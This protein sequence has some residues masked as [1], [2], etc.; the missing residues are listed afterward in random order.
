MDL[1]PCRVMEMVYVPGSRFLNSYPPCSSVSALRGAPRSGPPESFTEIPA[2]PESA[3]SC[4]V[5][6]VPWMEPA[7]A[8][9]FAG[10]ASCANAEEIANKRTRAMPIRENRDQALRQMVLLI[11]GM[12]PAWKNRHGTGLIFRLMQRL[13]KPFFQFV[14]G[15]CFLWR[16]TF[17]SQS[18]TTRFRFIAFPI[19][20]AAR[21]EARSSR[22]RNPGTY[23]P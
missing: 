8:L 22:R 7:W 1:K 3:L 14:W 5:E 15:S 2:T 18:P 12:F 9:A 13:G 23:N 6:M 11:R 4:I 19:S 10:G 16:R 21:R 20:S 17:S